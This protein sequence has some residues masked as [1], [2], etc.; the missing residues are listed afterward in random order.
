MRRGR[1]ANHA[2]EGAIEATNSWSPCR[3]GHDWATDAAQSPPAQNDDD[4]ERG[5]HHPAPMP[6]RNFCEAAMYPLNIFLFSEGRPPLK[7]GRQ[8]GF[9]ILGKECTLLSVRQ[10]HIKRGNYDELRYAQSH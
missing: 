2:K 6:R 9:T 4:A 10:R 1:G 7:G 3:Q 5:Q 8:R